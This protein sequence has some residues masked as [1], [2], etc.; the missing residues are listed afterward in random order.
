VVDRHVF[1]INQG[2]KRIYGTLFNHW[3][4]YAYSAS[5]CVNKQ[6]TETNIK[7]TDYL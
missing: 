3:M 7:C 2:V 5:D 1:L 4:L 6:A